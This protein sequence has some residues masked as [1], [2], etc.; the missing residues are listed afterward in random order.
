LPVRPIYAFNFLGSHRRRRRLYIYTDR[1]YIDNGRLGITAADAT[2]ILYIRYKHIYIYIYIYKYI[3]Y[4]V[5][6]RIWR[7]IAAPPPTP[8]RDLSR[9]ERYLY[10]II[11]YFVLWKAQSSFVIFSHTFSR[12]VCGYNNIAF[13]LIGKQNVRTK[14][15]T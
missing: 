2:Y 13:R 12:P 4:G 7:R 3:K 1:Y 6:L 10:Y 5:N 9:S 8:E 14:T 11:L 15:Y